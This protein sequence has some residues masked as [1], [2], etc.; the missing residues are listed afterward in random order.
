MR[1]Q[2]LLMMMAV[3]V[4]SY[5]SRIHAQSNTQPQVISTAPGPEDMLLDT[6]GPPRL[7]ISCGDFFNIRNANRKGALYYYN[8]QDNVAGEFN[9][10]ALPPKMEFFPHGI[11]MQ[12]RETKLYVIVHD[13]DSKHSSVVL[14][15]SKADNLEFAEEIR[16]EKFIKASANDLTVSDDGN[17]RYC[18][19]GF[20]LRELHKAT[21]KA[22]Y[23]AAAQRATAIIL[24]H[25]RETPDSISW[26]PNNDLFFGLAGT[27]LYFLH[28]GENEKAI[29]VAMTLISRAIKTDSTYNWRFDQ[30]RPI[31]LPNFSHGAAGVGF[32]FVRLFQATRRHDFLDV[33]LKT[34]KYLSTIARKDNGRLMIPYSLPELNEEKRFDLGWAHGSAGVARFYYELFKATNNIVWSEK[35]EA[36]KRTIITSGIPF[37]VKPEFGLSP[38]DITQRFGVAGIASFLIDDYRINRTPGS[39]LYAEVLTRY[40]FDN[41]DKSNQTISWPLKRFVFMENAGSVTKFTGNMYGA[42]GIGQLFVDMHYLKTDTKPR[43]RF[44]DDPF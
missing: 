43:I 31:I 22:E 38:L 30:Q 9:L 11:A 12:P 3:L 5:S 35:L 2:L 27:G 20:I 28:A 16:N 18:G 24:K 21:K 42:S 1:R 6:S 8:I 15:N 10:M 23:E 39:L 32:F 37:D 34:E 29:K 44:I 14:F 4:G 17:E 33:A 41:S 7:I 25:A 19:S 26:T 13:R 40:L 36:C